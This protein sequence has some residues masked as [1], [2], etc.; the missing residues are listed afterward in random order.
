MAVERGNLVAADN[1]TEGR[2]RAW[3]GLLSGGRLG[4]GAT[5]FNEGVNVHYTRLLL[6]RAGLSSVD[7]YG[8]DANSSAR[9]YCCSTQ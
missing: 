8:R 4:S 6:M 1:D 7:E 9:A 2:A 3:I 5:W